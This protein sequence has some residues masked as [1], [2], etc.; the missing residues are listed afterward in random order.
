MKKITMFIIAMMTMSS[1]AFA[2]HTSSDTTASSPTP[3]NYTPADNT[4]TPNYTPIEIHYQIPV[5][6]NGK[7]VIENKTI[8]VAGKA[9]GSI[10]TNKDGSYVPVVEKDGKWEPNPKQSSFNISKVEI[11]A[12]NEI[13]S[14]ALNNTQS[15]ITKVTKKTDGTDSVVAQNTTSITKNSTAIKDTQSIIK[16]LKKD[17]KNG[18]N[19]K[20]TTEKIVKIDKQVQNNDKRIANNSHRISQVSERVDENR[21]DI[22]HT[23]ALSASLAA[24]HPMQYDPIHPNQILA[25]LGFYRGKQ[26][27]AV[28]VTHYFNENFMTT[29][30][31]AGGTD[32]K[33][34]LMANI[35]LTWKIGGNEYR[36]SR[37][38]PKMYDGKQMQSIYMLQ[39]Q[40]YSLMKDNKDLILKNQYLER[41]VDKMDAMEKRLAEMEKFV[42]KLLKK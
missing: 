34:D 3:P 30:G 23:G 35:G 39:T 4:N 7:V 41:K 26:G 19:Y 32:S 2:A 33:N 16:D 6:N 9:D 29:V 27:V 21:R 15:E 38:L 22:S 1:M 8:K 11:D 25:G 5:L 12:A 14:K 42:N 28:G 17:I 36:E 20:D 18:G 40:V 10:V 37:K 31:V 13:Y 24:L